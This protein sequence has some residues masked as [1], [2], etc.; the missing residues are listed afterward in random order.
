VGTEKILKVIGPAILVRFMTF[1]QV[2]RINEVVGI[3]EQI[4]SH[5]RGAQGR[6]DDGDGRDQCRR[7]RSPQD[8]ALRSTNPTM[9]KL[10]APNSKNASVEVTDWLAEI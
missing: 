3:H 9:P 4:G 5:Y 8:Q 10:P 7:S 2:I 6:C 1:S